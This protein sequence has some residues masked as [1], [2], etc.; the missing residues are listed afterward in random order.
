MDFEEHIN[1]DKFDICGGLQEHKLQGFLISTMPRLFIWITRLCVLYTSYST[2]EERLSHRPTDV[3]LED[4]KYLS[5]DIEHFMTRDEIL[6]SIL[7]QRSGYVQGIGYGKKPL[8]KTIMQQAN[9]K[10]SVS[11]VKE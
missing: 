5:E 1:K 2:D 6:L 9:I 10:S 3:K 8:R 7:G 11:L 4:R